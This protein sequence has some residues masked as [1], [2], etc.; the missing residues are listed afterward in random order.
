MMQI[1]ISKLRMEMNWAHENSDN[2]CPLKNVLPPRRE[3]PNAPSA[4]RKTYFGASKRA[5]DEMIWLR[6]DLE[7]NT[8][9]NPSDMSERPP[10]C[11]PCMASRVGSRVSSASLWI[12]L[13]FRIISTFEF[14]A[15]IVLA[16]QVSDVR[17]ASFLSLW[18]VCMLNW[19]S[20][21][22]I[23]PDCSSVTPLVLGAASPLA[24]KIQGL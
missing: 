20:H 7:I 14:I 16:I 12:F 21:H 4:A 10:H 18:I 13:W 11:H 1:I 23:H 19:I 6:I 8:S 3:W 9:P 15:L 22:T 17:T 24:L 2:S 5:I